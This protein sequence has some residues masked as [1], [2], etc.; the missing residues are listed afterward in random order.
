MRAFF[1]LCACLAGFWLAACSSTPA[2]A[3]TLQA[4]EGG[5]IVVVVDNP[6][7]PGVA[8]AGSTPQGYDGMPTYS[9]SAS[10]RQAVATLEQKYGLHSVRSWAI[11]QLK[12]YCVVFA[13]EQPE[14]RSTVLAAL[15]Q[16]PLVKSAQALQSFNTLSAPQADTQGAGASHPDAR[17]NDP[18]LGLQGSFSAIDAG[19]AQQWARGDGVRV[20]VIDTGM[21][22]SHPD[23]RGRISAQRNFVDADKAQF[24]RDRHGTEVAGIIAANANNHE[25]IVGIAPAV[26]I[27]ALKACWQPAQKNASSECNSFT[28]A[29]ALSAALDADAQ[30]INLSLGGPAD[31]LLAQLVR[32]ALD[33]GVVVVGAVPPSGQLDG[34]PVGISGVLAVDSSSGGHGG[35][36]VLPAPGHDV[37]TL[38][39][40]GH[41]DYASGSSLATAH[42]SGAVALLLSLN[43]HLS[44][45]T[46][47]STMRHSVRQNSDGS[48]SINLCLAVASLRAGS[49]CN[50]ALGALQPR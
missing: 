27:I 38:T 36:L 16:D 31:P 7:E 30:V 34:F 3:V 26:K 14:R 42:V 47:A 40:G 37:L 18:Y 12:V 45:S 1:V 17:Y 24:Q 50:G 32:Y 44:V 46:I 23:L 41:Y 20:A 48:S 22:A 10:A 2:T 9:V 15:A 11:N 49:N 19:G 35:S 13:V 28:L 39:P 8:H 25:G 43:A 6:V 4:G 29:E 5:M 21:D 33:H